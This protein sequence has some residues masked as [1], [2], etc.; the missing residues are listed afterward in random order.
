[1]PMYPP[2][3]HRSHLTPLRFLQRSA[4]VFRH[5]PAVVYGDR[6]WTYPEFER[7]RPPP[8]L[9]LA[10]RGHREGRPGRLPAAEHPG[11]AGR[12]LRR[13][14][15]RRRPGRDQHPAQPGRDRLHPQPLR[16]QGADRRHR[17]G[18]AGRAGAR[19][20]STDLETIV[21]VE[22]VPGGV[23][24]AGTRLRERSWPAAVRAPLDWP[25]DD[26]D[27]TIAINYTSGTTGRPK[28]V[29]YTHRG[30]YLNA[31]GELLETRM[32]SDSVYLWTLP[33]FHCNGWCYPWAVTAIGA[34][35]VCLRKFDAGRGLGA[36]PRGRASPTS[37]PRR[38]C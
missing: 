34:T 23:R 27:E 21:T 22:D 33:M 37:A 19:A 26:E 31:L 25:L 7:A 38:R 8:G 35:H 11:D 14:A 15:G 28:G 30:A 20:S 36:G 13:A 16:R 18:A 24:L 9:G 32:A 10:R 17:A 12:A 4:A 29:M 1:M 2:E 6:T 5:K 3:V